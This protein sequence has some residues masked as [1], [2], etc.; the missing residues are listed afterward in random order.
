MCQREHNAGDC[1]THCPVSL[2]TTG[3]GHKASTNAPGL[4][5]GLSHARTPYDPPLGSHQR[6]VFPRGWGAH[7][8]RS[9]VRGCVLPRGCVVTQCHT[10]HS[11]FVRSNLL[12]RIRNSM[13]SVASVFNLSSS[14]PTISLSN[15]A[16]QGSLS[17]F[18]RTDGGQHPRCVSC[19][20]S[21]L[22]PT[23]G[24][25]QGRHHATCKPA[26]GSCAKC[27]R[28]NRLALAAVQWEYP[29][30]P[31]LRRGTTVL[32]RSW[33][34]ESPILAVSLGWKLQKTYKGRYE[35]N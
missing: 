35:Y 18:C 2:S 33:L 20:A 27:H 16:K 28:T 12:N 5:A 15:R 30:S 29:M 11:T 13:A 8:W 4:T 21:V 23:A 34:V 25:L 17:A 22:F 14:K 31:S 24:R 19:M 26:A 7:T 6:R 1:Q 10:V 3:H 9:V 32:F